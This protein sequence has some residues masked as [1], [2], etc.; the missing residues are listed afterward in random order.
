MY[1]LMGIKCLLHILH[2]QEAVPDNHF[3]LL[4]KQEVFLRYCLENPQEVSIYWLE[5]LQ[6]GH[7]A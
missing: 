2:P 5:L 7:M 4:G 1:H 3:P 6:L